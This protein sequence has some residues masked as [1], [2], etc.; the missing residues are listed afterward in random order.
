MKHLFFL[1][2]LLF[3][4]CKSEDDN[5]N[6]C[7]QENDFTLSCSSPSPSIVYGTQEWTVENA[8]H[9][10]YRDGTPIPQVTDEVEWT[11]LTTGAWCYYDNDPS[12]G[13]L[14]N[15]YAVMGI[16]DNISNTPN[17]VFAPLGWHVPSH[18]EWIT[19]EGYLIQNGYNSEAVTPI[20]I[21]YFGNRF[22]NYLAKSLASSSGWKCPN[23]GGQYYLSLDQSTNN[24]SGF[25]AFP[26]GNRFV[27]YS[28]GTT[29][30][31]STFMQWGSEARFW[32][33]STA[34]DSA[35]NL[36]DPVYSSL[37][38]NLWYSILGRQNG[39]SVRLLKN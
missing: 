13:V 24:S 7:N 33:S 18:S 30:V 39:L 16:H 21:P 17:K 4:A 8:C 15:W 22:N 38:S 35:N 3:F 20:P 10:S 12:K 36:T 34:Y 28:Q 29:P 27:S 6:D 2:A 23:D 25:N 5:N 9:T 37:D 31:S 11:N 14:Y 26:A 1:S 32:S 19:F